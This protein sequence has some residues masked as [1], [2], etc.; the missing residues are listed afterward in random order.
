MLG[1]LVGRAVLEGRV[2]T[3]AIVPAF[4]VIEQGHACLLARGPR[5]VGDEFTL[6]RG[7]KLSATALSQQL[8]LRLMLATAP[9]W[10]R[11]C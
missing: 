1:V 9:C 11:Q 2:P 5:G 10:V 6:E 4:E 7:K 8:P 3:T